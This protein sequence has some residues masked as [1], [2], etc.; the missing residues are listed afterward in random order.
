MTVQTLTTTAGPSTVAAQIASRGYSDKPGRLPEPVARMAFEVY[1][2]L[3][4]SQSFAV[5]HDRGG[6]GV[7]ELVAFLY[8]R[9]F[10]KA[11]WQMRVD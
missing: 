10:P 4:S 8:A 11:E 1:H 3:Y 5:L 2:H 9:N 7:G 6:F